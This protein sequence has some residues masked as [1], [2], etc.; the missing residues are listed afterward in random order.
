MPRAAD[1]PDAPLKRLGGGRWQTRDERFTIEPQSGTWVIVDATQTDELG[2]PLVRGPFGSL[3]AAKDAIAEARSAAPPTSPLEGR[4]RSAPAEPDASTP[5]R[6]RK[7]A[8]TAKGTP[9]KGTSAKAAPP[10][11]PSSPRTPTKPPPEPE[12]PRWLR[13]LDPEDRRRARTAVDRLRD[14]G[15]PDPEGMV[16]RDVVGDVPAI[17]AWAIR[18]AMV[19]AGADASPG[20]VA[21]LLAEGRDADLG[22]RWHLVDGDGRRIR[23]DL[24]DVTDR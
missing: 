2:L 14:A 21:E 15:A 18:R 10:A 20:A 13:D 9:G 4:P 8:P 22:V 12:E 11:E 23:L 17:A 19:A 1:D 16:R 7:G 5:A 3:G 6:G 24:D